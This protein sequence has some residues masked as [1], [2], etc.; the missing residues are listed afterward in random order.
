MYRIHKVVLAYVRL[1]S[2]LR[3]V[4]EVLKLVLKAIHESTFLVYPCFQRTGLWNV[5]DCL[6]GNNRNNNLLKILQRRY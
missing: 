5:Y 2:I 3:I 4:F 6:E 1:E